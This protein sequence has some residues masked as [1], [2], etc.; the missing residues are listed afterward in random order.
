MINQVENENQDRFRS[1]MVL[2]S[3]EQALASFVAERWSKLSVENPTYKQILLREPLLEGHEF[4]KDL[5]C[6]VAQS[7]YLK[8]LFDLGLAV[9]EGTQEAACL[10]ELIGLST[11]LEIFNIRNAAAHPNRRFFQYFWFRLAAIAADPRIVRLGLFDVCEGLERAIQGTINSPPPEWFKKLPET[12]NNLPAKFDHTSTGLIGRD[13]ERRRLWDDFSNPRK[14]FF[15]IVAPGGNGKTALALDFLDELTCSMR[16]QEIVDAVV[17]VSMK[18][19]SLTV[20]GLI[21]HKV[22]KTLREIEDQ[23][24]Q[25]LAT[26]YSES[27]PSFSEAKK[28]YSSQ[29]VVLCI[30]NL[31]TL[32]LDQPNVLNPFESELPEKWRLIV[33][34]RIP[35]DDAV[36]LALNPLKLPA[37]KQLVRQYISSCGYPQP[38]QS[39]VDSVAKGTKCNPLAVK[40][41]IDAYVA[42]RDI[43]ESISKAVSDTTEYSFS[44]LIEVLPEPCICVMESLFVDDEI[45]RFSLSEA[46]SFTPDVVTKAIY[47]LCRTSLVT[48][49]P[50]N[51]GN[52]E[53]FRLNDQV[54]EL[55]RFH[56]KRIGVREKVEKYL[57]GRRAQAAEK[58]MLNSLDDRYRWDV[59]EDHLPEDLKVI[60]HKVNQATSKAKSAS[61]KLPDVYRQLMHTEVDFAALPTYWRTRARVLWEL[62]DRSA[63]FDCLNKA[64]E[65]DEGDVISRK[66]LAEWLIEDQRSS[67]ALPHLEILMSIGADNPDVFGND[68]ASHVIG[69]HLYAQIFLRRFEDVANATNKWIEREDEIGWVKATARIRCFLR[70]AEDET[71]E[72]SEKRFIYALTEFDSAAQHF[73]LSP[74][75]EHLGEELIEE[76]CR[77]LRSPKKLLSEEIARSGIEFIGKYY[78]DLVQPDRPV[79]C[80]VEKALPIIKENLSRW[81][82][83][84]NKTDDES[85]V[86]LKARYQEQGYVIARI[87]KPLSFYERASTSFLFAKDEQGEDYFVHA[88]SFI[89]DS[90]YRWKDLKQDSTVAIKRMAQTEGSAKWRSIETRLISLG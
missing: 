20:N 46:L 16:G 52:R 65:L 45:S 58:S 25:E 18:T 39:L 67:E 10:A 80:V 75:M 15:A 38:D 76:I 14:H 22:A 9:T 43:S 42:G 57:R 7:S 62:Q 73:G 51:L 81:N 83:S 28:M 63:G 64:L 30:D 2:C 13:E 21:E 40:L 44:N 78:Q 1:Q 19:N 23:I 90:S 37:A 17:F 60:V 82:S 27:L 47:D 50:S 33:T 86:D 34:S 54:R 84:L 26:V 56:P 32:L 29:R 88:S 89:K 77:R 59:I 5:V 79:Y 31:E 71:C 53:I 66:M 74:S 55:L 41:V 85:L 87:V 69:S 24:C 12:P 68:F 6:L 4:S 8:E 48:R 11:E 49:S 35:V 3:I 36:S 72:Q 70:W 61:T